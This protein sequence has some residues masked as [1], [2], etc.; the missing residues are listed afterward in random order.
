LVS[1]SEG[2]RAI[3]GAVQGALI[4]GILN[5]GLILQDVSFLAAR[6]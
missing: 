6:H 4:I 5:N 2:K 3:P 1:L